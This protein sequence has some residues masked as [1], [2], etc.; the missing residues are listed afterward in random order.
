[1]WKFLVG[2]LGLLFIISAQAAVYSTQIRE[3]DRGDGKEKILVLLANGKVSYLPANS[4]MAQS[5]ELAARRGTL[6]KL[7]VNNSREITSAQTL[8]ISEYD[9]ENKVLASDRSKSNRYTPTVVASFDKAKEIFKGLNR[10]ANEESQCYNRAH[11][12]SW[13]MY[14]DHLVRPNKVFIFFTHKYIRRYNFEW[15]FHVSPYVLTKEGNETV[16]RVMDFKYSREPKTMK[17]WTD[18]FMHN[19]AQCTDIEKYT[20][21][22]YNRSSSSSPWCMLLRSSMYYYQPLDLEKLDKKGETKD[23]WVEWEINNAYREAFSYRH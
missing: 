6:L 7:N 17:E 3:V 4:D 1:M 20:D 5:F 13:E 11:V 23:F 19:N 21:Y 8:K 10:R 14:N 9:Y 18:I 2:C 16:E 22:E 15:W 12:W